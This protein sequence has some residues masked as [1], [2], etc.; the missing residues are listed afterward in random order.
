MDE[1]CKIVA[2]VLWVGVYAASRQFA[3]Q[4]LVEDRFVGREFVHC[5]VV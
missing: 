4:L 3:E 1:Y 2:R 5:G